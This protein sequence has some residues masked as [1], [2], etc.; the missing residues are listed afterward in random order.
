[1]VSTP[2]RLILLLKRIGLSQGSCRLKVKNDK[3]DTM[4]TL[5]NQAFF[6][7]SEPFC[8]IFIA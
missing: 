6:P 7:W 8:E 4:K 3:P 1:M 5:D 2:F